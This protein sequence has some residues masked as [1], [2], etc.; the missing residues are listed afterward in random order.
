MPIMYMNIKT[1]IWNLQQDILNL[2]EFSYQTL[3]LNSTMISLLVRG[4]IFILIV[5][6][7]LH[8]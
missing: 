6:F 2:G 1:I 3:I 7:S 5:D 8:Y 4:E